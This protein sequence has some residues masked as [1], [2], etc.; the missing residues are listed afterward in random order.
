MFKEPEPTQGQAMHREVG[1][2]IEPKGIR[3]GDLR[4]VEFAPEQSAP[5]LVSPDC[6]RTSPVVDFP[7]ESV[8]AREM[9]HRLTLIA[10]SLAGEN[11]EGT[12]GAEFAPAIAEGTGSAQGRK[13][14]VA[15]AVVFAASGGHRPQVE[16][17]R[18]SAQAV[19]E[20]L[21]DCHSL[22]AEILGL[23]MITRRNGDLP[24]RGVARCLE[25]PSA[26]L[27]GTRERE[28]ELPPRLLDCAPRAQDE[29]ATVGEA[30]L[31]GRR[32][33]RVE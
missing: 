31:I 23:A 18:R 11:P 25:I 4:L 6:R 13:E 24:E 21:E 16:R 20:R 14:I 19:A 12:Q 9:G 32:S 33:E 10:R 15:R 17:H 27:L 22:V 3:E 7:R 1:V 26:G 2:L 30:R 29:A 28:G 8:R 5:P